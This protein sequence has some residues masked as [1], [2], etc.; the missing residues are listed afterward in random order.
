M[1]FLVG[2]GWVFFG[3]VGV[4]VWVGALFFSNE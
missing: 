2:F 1:T 3:G 4:G